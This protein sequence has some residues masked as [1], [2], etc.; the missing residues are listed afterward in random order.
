MLDVR[1]SRE[2]QGIVL[3]LKTAD[4]PVRKEM[5]AAARRELNALWKPT[6]DRFVRTP[7]QQKVLARGARANVQSDT[8]TLLAATSRRALSGGLVP[9]NRWQ[10][11]EFGANPKQV[12]VQWR[13]RQ[14]RQTIGKNFGPRT[15]KGNVVYPAVRKVGPR[16]VAAW[17]NGIVKGLAQGN[18]DMETS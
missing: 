17:V 10:G 12:S 13:G 18:K 7:Q 15:P 5:R 2:L 6:I 16:V 9:V 4:R 8:F 3:L 1:R 14:R 11:T